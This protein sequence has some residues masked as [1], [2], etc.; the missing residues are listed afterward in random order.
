[1]CIGYS[2]SQAPSLWRIY[3]AEGVLFTLEEAPL[4]SPF[5]DPLDTTLLAAGVFRVLLAGRSFLQS[6]A[7]TAITVRL[8]Q[9]TVSLLRGR[10]KLGLSGRNLKMTETAAKHMYNPGR[11]VPLQLQ[12]KAIRYGRRMPDP[13]RKAGYFRYEH[14]MYRLIEDKVNKTYTYKKYTLEVI[15]REKDWTISHLLLNAHL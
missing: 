14:G 9:S 11:Y 13:Q 1:M 10:L 4:E 6:G 12:E 2:V 5:I 15:V 8:S 7:R 3:D